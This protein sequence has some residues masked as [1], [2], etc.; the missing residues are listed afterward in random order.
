MSIIEIIAVLFSLA[1][2]ILTIKNKVWCWP[3]GIVGIFFYMILF[4]QHNI[5]GNAILQLLF[6][7]QSVYGWYK[8]GEPS[9]YPI[10]WLDSGSRESLIGATGLLAVLFSII[11]QNKGGQNPYLDGTTTALSIMAMLLMAY[12]KI[13]SWILWMIADVIFIIF[14]YING[15]YLSSGIYTV[16]LILAIFGLFEWRKSIKMG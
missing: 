16:F 8:W 3:V 1:S 10:K 12:R 6:I 5:V 13:E 15:L 14:F 11:I 2:V 7:A 9:K 4:L